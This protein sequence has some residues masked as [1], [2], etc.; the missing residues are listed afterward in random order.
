MT[1]AHCIT[2]GDN[3][4]P[5]GE[6]IFI[7]ANMFDG[8][9]SE[10]TT[11]IAQTILHPCWN[12]NAASNNND[13]ALVRLAQASTITPATWNTNAAVPADGD[14]VTVM[15]YGET[16]TDGQGVF[17]DDLL[18]TTVNVVSSATCSLSWG[19]LL[20]PATMLCAAA[21]GKDSCQGDS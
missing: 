13:I 17:P 14:P 4:F 16:T 11:T 5:V 15:G 20:L 8:T 9:D 12:F 10:F 1:A 3:A 2:I 19:S 7:G 18:Q 6:T 21:P